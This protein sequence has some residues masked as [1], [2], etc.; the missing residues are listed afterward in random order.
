MPTEITIEVTFDPKTDHAI[1]FDAKVTD[2]HKTSEKSK[3][4]LALELISELRKSV[5]FFDEMQLL[6]SLGDL[7]QPRG[8]KRPPDPM[9]F[10]DMVNVPSLWL[11][12]SNTFINLRF[13]LAQAKAYKNLEP[14]S[15]S[16]VSDSLCA[17]LHFEKIYK[18]NLAVFE[19]VKI[20]DLVVRLL[21]E[22]FGGRLITVNYDKEGWEKGLRLSDAID[23]LEQFVNRGELS[24]SDSDAIKNALEL[25]LRS[26]HRKIIVNYRNRVA[27][28]IRPS[29]DYPELYTEVHS[30]AG[31]L[32]KDAKG[33]VVGRRY[34]LGNYKSAPD[35]QF[36]ELYAAVTEYMSRISEMLKALREIPR[37]SF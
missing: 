1:T 10:L 33:T 20:Q 35:F 9:G 7:V 4:N 14:H 26:P 2:D 31:E 29:V 21:Q 5:S 12:I 27:H 36:D 3:Q 25:P 19:L 18:L 17:H 22:G 34:G 37:L 30:R 15:Y 11:E 13:V 6:P 8:S 24:N 32:I 28:G 16:P 23:G